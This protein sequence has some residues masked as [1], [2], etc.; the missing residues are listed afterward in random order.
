M[1]ACVVEIGL[2]P[3]RIGSS[4]SVVSYLVSTCLVLQDVCATPGAV[5]GLFNTEP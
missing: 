4:F 5:P 3:Y 1:C 2:D